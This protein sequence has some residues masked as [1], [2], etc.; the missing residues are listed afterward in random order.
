MDMKAASDLAAMIGTENVVSGDA[1]RAYATADLFP[2]AGQ[3]PALLVLT[4]RSTR[5][6]AAVLAYLHGV[7]LPVVPRGAGLSYTGGVSPRRPSVVIDTRKLK[8]IEINAD[9]L[10]ARVGAGTPWE[11]LA[12]ALRPYELKCAQPN[13]ISGSHST[14]GGTAA[15]G[16]PGG[17]E[18][19]LGVTV[20]LADG[21]AVRTGAAT[22]GPHGGFW[23]YN[24]PDL[25]GLFLGDCGAFGIKT[26]LIVRLIPNRPAAF[27]SFSFADASSLLDAMVSI[28]RRG[29][30]TRAIA[31]DPLKSRDA[32]TVD[33][34]QAAGIL[35]AV[36]SQSGSIT[37]SIRDVAHLARSAMSKKPDGWALHLTAEAVTAIGAEAQL[38]LAKKIC[39]RSGHEIDNVIPKTL[40]TKAYSI[41]GFV[42][43]QGERW[44]PIHG[45]LS[46]SK[47]RACMDDLTAF[48][49]SKATVLN[50]VGVSVN[51]LI[52]SIGAYITIE[53]MFYWKDTLDPI[54]FRHLTPRNAERF[55]HAAQNKP[56][57]DAI[58]ALRVELRAIY[59]AHG[60]VHA[61]TGRFYTLPEQATPLLHKIKSALDPNGSMNPGVLGL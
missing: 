38:S 15:Q 37:Q 46:L 8:D 27:A 16:I 17:T 40:H 14:V 10:Y 24:G 12:D 47:A 2:P 4:P 41:R 28:L 35:G 43:P 19:F 21:T 60:A 5:E 7:G 39:E 23:R 52:S 44:V 61:Q 29:L 53:G 42:G 36:V 58:A 34:A 6:T 1:E 9:D 26:E 11:T 55:S 51:W 25:T 50:Q 48:I 13:P 45:I 54:H 20:V 18:G 56:A 22:G 59:D 31:M 57:R 3:T 49:N 33:V 30:V 32:T